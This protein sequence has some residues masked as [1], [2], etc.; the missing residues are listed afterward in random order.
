MAHGESNLLVRPRPFDDTREVDRTLTSS[1]PSRATWLL[2]LVT[3]AL[4]VTGLRTQIVPPRSAEPISR[5][6]GPGTSSDIGDFYDH[7]PAYVA[8]GRASGRARHTEPPE[9][10]W[11]FWE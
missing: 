1:G 7:V 10:K 4:P 2:I 9:V 6:Y 8:D 11:D 5:V 3:N